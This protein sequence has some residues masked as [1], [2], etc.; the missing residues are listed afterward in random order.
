[1]GDVLFGSQPAE[2]LNIVESAKVMTDR[3]EAAITIWTACTTCF[4]PHH[5]MHLPPL[6]MSMQIEDF[7]FTM[8]ASLDALPHKVSGDGGNFCIQGV[9][10][11]GKTTV[12]KAVAIVA[13]FLLDYVPVYWNFDRNTLA[14]NLLPSTLIAQTISRHF[15]HAAESLQRFQQLASCSTDD[16][17]LT[18][19]ALALSP[20]PIIFLGDEIQSIY[21][22]TNSPDCGHCKQI[23]QQLY[24]LGKMPK[25][26][27]LL[28]GSSSSLR[29]H[30]FNHP[31]FRS[32]ND[33]VYEMITILPI[34]Q[35]DTLKSYVAKR[36]PPLAQSIDVDLL[37]NHT[38][39]V[40]R[41]IDAFDKKLLLAT[42]CPQGRDYDQ[43]TRG[44]FH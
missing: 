44:S 21:V 37:Y 10:G 14:S 25:F 43:V 26:R 16:A 39:G 35:L 31:Y 34:R 20:N 32:L 3:L 29:Q 27:G 41:H 2:F 7:L 17:A 23:I 11:V 42:A 15:P 5:P 4:P 40:G 12:L 30:L 18:R 19:H 22:Q 33:S 6:Y 28:T 1:M 36:Y 9:I 38:G 8:L 24:N 13:R